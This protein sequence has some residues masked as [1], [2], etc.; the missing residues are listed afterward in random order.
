MYLKV[1]KALKVVLLILV[2][3]LMS[4]TIILLIII[5][6]KNGQ[7]RCIFKSLEEILKNLEEILKIYRVAKKHGITWNLTIYAKKKTWNFV[8]KSW[9]NLELF[10]NLYFLTTFM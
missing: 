10:F 7:K 6:T 3:I 8:G 5:Y 2:I 9:K 1:F 4:F